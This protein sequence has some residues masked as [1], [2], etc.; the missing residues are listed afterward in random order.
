MRVGKAS[1]ITRTASMTPEQRSWSRT[2]AGV[3]LLAACSALGL[4][5]RMKEAREAWSSVSSELRSLTKR[6]PTEEKEAA[7]LAFSLAAWSSAK[8]SLS[9]TTG[10]AISLA[11]HSDWRVSLFFS[12]QGTSWFFVDL[13]MISAV[14]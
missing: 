3:K 4:M 12:S 6:L 5:Q 8:S 2:I 13:E 14:W 10:E 1:S 11:S 9:R 7:F